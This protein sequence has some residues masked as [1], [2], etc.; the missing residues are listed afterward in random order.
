MTFYSS[1]AALTLPSS[2][3]VVSTGAADGGLGLVLVDAQN[4]SIAPCEYRMTVVVDCQYDAEAEVLRVVM[5]TSQ[6]DID[7]TFTELNMN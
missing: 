2:V 1:A 7:S 5:C 3:S 4:R 6:I